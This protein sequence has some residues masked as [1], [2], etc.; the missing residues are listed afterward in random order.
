M[1][2]LSKRGPSPLNSTFLSALG[3]VRLEGL[4]PPTF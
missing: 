1:C 2:G 3:G 4:E